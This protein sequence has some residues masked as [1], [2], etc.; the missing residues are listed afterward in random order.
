[1]TAPEEN[2]D[3]NDLIKSVEKEHGAG[4][5]R[6]G[7]DEDSIQRLKIHSIPT[8]SLNLDQATGIGGIPIGRITEIYGPESS[9]KSTL[10]VHIMGEAQKLDYSVAYIDAEHALDP[11]YAT[12]CGLDINK[13]LISQP[14]SAEQALNVVSKLIEDGRI[15]LIVVDSVH[16]MVPLDEVTNNIGETTIALLPRIMST[17]LRKINPALDRKDVALVFT[18]QLRDTINSYGPKETTTGG[19]ALKFYSSMRIALRRAE[20]I[21]DRGTIIGHTTKAQVIKNKCARPFRSTTFDIYFDEGISMTS[22]VLDNAVES[23]IIDKK[24]AF[25]YYQ[26]E[27]IGQGKDAAREALKSNPTMMAEITEKLRQPMTTEG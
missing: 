3:F 13:L 21:K 26:E 11:I 8:G 14:D 4:A 20:P 6:H 16:A 23:E 15:R 27:R 1:M 10:A 9:G 2:H 19:R 5:I 22:E 12:K 18:N 24:G 7:S 17:S 25:Y